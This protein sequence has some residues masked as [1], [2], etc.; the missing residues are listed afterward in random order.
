MNAIYA[1]AFEEAQLT[2]QLVAKKVVKDGDLADMGIPL[3]PRRKILTS[4]QEI[5]GV[6]GDDYED[7]GE[8]V[9]VHTAV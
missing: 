1:Q 8:D 6:D 4:I 7:N 5:G 9:K 2:W 3:G